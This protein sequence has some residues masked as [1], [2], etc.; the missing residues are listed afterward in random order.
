MATNPV[1]FSADDLLHVPVPPHLLGYELVDGQLVEVTPAWPRHG[2]ITGE[3]VHRIADH[4]ERSA[5]AG[6]VYIDAGYV[7]GL[8]RDRERM[9]APDVSFVSA[10]TLAE[11]GGEPER[12]WFRL[13]PD[14]AIEVDSPGRKPRI[15]QQRI[16]DYQDAGVRMLWVIHTTTRTASV[17]RPGR[18]V[19]TVKEGEMLDGDDILPGL[20]LPLRAIL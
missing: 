17:Y 12:G 13:I 18:P 9:R 4:L 1:R 2:R 5:V 14:L 15:E 10:A 11:H 19:H 16:Q 3:L 6:H 20:I 8:A 7:L